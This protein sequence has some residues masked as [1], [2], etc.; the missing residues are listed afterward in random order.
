MYVAQHCIGLVDEVEDAIDDSQAIRG[1]I[2][3]DLNRDS[4]PDAIRRRLLDRRAA[5]DQDGKRA[6]G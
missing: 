6:P 3:I 5:F 4:T 1:F 2:V